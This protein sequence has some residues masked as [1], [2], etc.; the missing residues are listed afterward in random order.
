MWL[1]LELTVFIIFSLCVCWLLSIH[2]VWVDLTPLCSFLNP[3]NVAFTS[4]L[5]FIWSQLT[6]ICPYMFFQLFDLCAGDPQRM[7]HYKH[8]YHEGGIEGL[9]VCPDCGVPLLVQGWGGKVT[10][11]TMHVI[12]K[13]T[14][15]CLFF[16]AMVGLVLKLQVVRHIKYCT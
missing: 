12:N 8:Q 16:C 1:S 10:Y 3:E 4:V 7:A 6:G 5:C 15:K 13:S 14:D 11:G 2:A 9:L